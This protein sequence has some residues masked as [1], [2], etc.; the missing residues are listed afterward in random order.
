MTV[1]SG[2][3]VIHF[4]DRQVSTRLGDVIHI[5]SGTFHWAAK[6]GSAEHVVFAEFSPPFDGK[7]RRFVLGVD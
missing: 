5:P 6:V 4:K 1:L 2:E 3:G 7:D